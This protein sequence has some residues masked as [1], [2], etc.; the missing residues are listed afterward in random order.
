MK[1]NLLHTNIEQFY[2]MYFTS[3]RKEVTADE[4]TI[5]LVKGQNVI[6]C[7]KRPNVKESSLMK[8]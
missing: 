2:Y 4:D 5:N 1:F 7:V 6:K 3:Y 8:N